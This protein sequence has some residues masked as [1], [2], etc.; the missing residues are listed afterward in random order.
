MRREKNSFL[1]SWVGKTQLFPTVC[2]FPVSL[3]CSP[4]RLLISNTWLWRL[5]LL[6]SKCVWGFPHQA[7]SLQC[8]LGVPQ[9]NSILPLSSQ[10]K[11]P[12]GDPTGYGLSPTRLSLSPF[13]CITCASDQPATDQRCQWPLSLGS[14]QTSG[15]HFLTFTVYE[16]TQ[17]KSLVKKG[18]IRSEG[19]CSKEALLPWS[20]GASPSPCGCVWPLEVLPAP[21]R[22]HYIGMIKHLTPFSDF[23]PS[24]ENCGGEGRGLLK[25]SSFKSW[26]GLSGDQFSSKNHSG[27]HPEL[28]R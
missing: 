11:C 26:L 5:R 2:F 13:R 6:I 20:L 23:L 17:V 3:Y 21:Q 4:R 19:S 8:Q 15:K 18:P 25:I 24:Q 16:R 1:S 28:P 7:K 12:P 27:A 14:S 10:R 22:L 9:F